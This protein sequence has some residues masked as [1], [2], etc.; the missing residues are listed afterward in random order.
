MQS[1]LRH[2]RPPVCPDLPP[3]PSRSVEELQNLAMLGYFPLMRTIAFALLALLAASILP[4]A[5]ARAAATDWQEVAPGIMLRLIGSGTVQDDGRLLVGLEVEMPPDTWTYWRV[6]GETGIPTT[7]AFDGS[8]G[9]DEPEVLWP[10]PTIHVAEGLTDFVYYGHVVLP[11]ALEPQGDEIALSASVL[12]GVCSDICIPVQAKLALPL[13]AGDSDAGQDLR[14][15]QA[16]AAVPLEWTKAIPAFEGVSFDAAAG[17][18]D[19]DGLGATIDPLSVIVDADLDGPLFGAPQKSQDSH[20]IMLP[21]LGG[22]VPATGAVRITFMTD[23]GAFFLWHE[24]AEAGST[25][26]DR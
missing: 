10:Y 14:L 2:D 5:A 21:L 17:T 7:I 15:S 24:M 13:R 4:V 25:S 26:A 11:I 23:E 8:T 3:W 22:T 9:I 6:P 12:M 1:I 18:L 16:R 20:G 19:I